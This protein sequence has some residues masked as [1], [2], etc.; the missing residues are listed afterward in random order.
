MENNPSCQAP[1]QHQPVRPRAADDPRTT[2]ARASHGRGLGR[3][4]HLNGQL[5][6]LLGQQD[7]GEAQLVPAIDFDL[8]EPNPWTNSVGHLTSQGPA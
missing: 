1:F 6:R 2:A 4:K 8:E 7:V 5:L 3:G